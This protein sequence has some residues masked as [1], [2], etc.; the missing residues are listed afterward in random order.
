MKLRTLALLGLAFISTAA[1]AQVNAL[2]PTRHI[3]VY[4]DAQARAVPD[5]YKI[6]M[7][8]EAIDADPAAAQARVE[9]HLQQTLAQLKAVGVA[10]NEIV[11][12][13]LQVDT[14]RRYDDKLRQEVFVGTG[15]RR[16]LSARFGG[17]EALER[18]LAK[19][20]TSEELTISSVA[21]ELSSEPELRRQLREKSI[22]S[23]REKAEVIARA[24]GARLG[25]VYSVSD[26]APQFDYGVREG[27][28]PALYAWS[29][30]GRD[31][32]QLDRIQVTGSRI[33]QAPSTSFQAGYIDFQDKIYTV[34]LLAD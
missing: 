18:F 7:Q 17:K 33:A 27:T 29:G 23:S 12:T 8:L 31:G 20:K 15:V 30:N 4:G 14:R 16:T 26:V 28:W 11:A 9:A 21:A 24:Y 19:V 3:L 6:A 2:P 25:G 10:D 32:Y 22:A 13:S 5:R 1:Q 34:F